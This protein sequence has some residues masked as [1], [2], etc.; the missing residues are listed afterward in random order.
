MGAGAGSLHLEIG[1]STLSKKARVSG[2]SELCT[3]SAES[4]GPERNGRKRAESGVQ[5]PVAVHSCLARCPQ[6]LGATA[7]SKAV[8]ERRSEGDWRRERSWDPTLSGPLE[9]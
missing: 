4:T 3:N 9:S 5:A 6:T 1:K 2:L 7:S 8:G